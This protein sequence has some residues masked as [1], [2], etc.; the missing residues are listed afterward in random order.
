[1]E[2]KSGGPMAGLQCHQLALEVPSAICEPDYEYAHLA[3]H[4]ISNLW[5]FMPVLEPNV[6]FNI[7]VKTPRTLSSGSDPALC[8]LVCIN[9]VPTM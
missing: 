5:F 1:M 6:M 4:G 8:Y 9:I 7:S 3:A 2:V